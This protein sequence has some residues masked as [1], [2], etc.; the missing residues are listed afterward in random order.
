MTRRD[1]AIWKYA[2][3]N[4]TNV[5]HVVT[6]RVDTPLVRLGDGCHVSSGDPPRAL[7]VASAAMGR[8]NMEM[9][10]EEVELWLDLGQRA[11]QFE[12]RSTAG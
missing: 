11:R 4:S 2:S 12:A 6:T 10:D 1:L 9:T 7:D 5:R 3:A 8:R